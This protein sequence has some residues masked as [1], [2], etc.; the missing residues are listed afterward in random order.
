MLPRICNEPGF[1]PRSF[2]LLFLPLAGATINFRTKGGMAQIPDD[3]QKT[4]LR[5]SNR[6]ALIPTLKEFQRRLEHL[7]TYLKDLEQESLALRSAA[8]NIEYVVE[9]LTSKE[10]F[11]CGPQIPDRS[12]PSRT[13]SD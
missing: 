11:G 1:R 6:E 4:V 3:L 12:H 13:Q 8:E 10:S 2:I 7:A 5:D 9:R